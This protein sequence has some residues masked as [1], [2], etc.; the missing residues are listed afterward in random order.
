M[1]RYTGLFILVIALVMIGGCTQQAQPVAVTTPVATA[2]LTVPPTAATPELTPTQEQTIVPTME[3]TI[4]SK[5]KITLVPQTTKTVI[6]IRNNTFS[7]V[8]LTVLPG[9]GISWVND[10]T[11]A[12]SVKTTGVHAGMFNSGDFIPTAS[13]DY[14]FGEVGV[15]EFI[16]PN[17]PDMKGKIVVKDGESVV[18]APTLQTPSP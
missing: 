15:F 2:V 1:K 17:Y 16:D 8:E 10:D 4:L 18:G 3:T 7:P 9:T 12:H 11:V 13:W 6:Y 14:T 5:P